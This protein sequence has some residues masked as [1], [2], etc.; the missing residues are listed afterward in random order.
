MGKSYDLA[1]AGAGFAGL[2]LA[3]FLN[4]AEKII[5]EAKSNIGAKQSSTCCTPLK[6]IEKLNCREAK[7]VEFKKFSVHS[8]NK[9]ELIV[10]LPEKFCTIDYARFCRKMLENIKNA[11]TI[12]G[13]RASI[14]D[15][16]RV[17]ISEKNRKKEI[18]ARAIADCSGWHAL[19]FNENIKNKSKKIPF[20]LEIEAEI[21]SYELARFHLFYGKKY[22]KKGYAWVFPV[23]KS[24][25]RVGLGGFDIKAP[26]KE[27]ARFLNFL[28]IENNA[29]EKSE[30]HANFIP[31]IGLRK[32]KP[33]KKVFCIGD[34]MHAVL[35][36]SGE[37]IRKSMEHAEI[38]TR[39]LKSYLEGELSLENAFEGYYR[40]I[41]SELPFYDNLLL[42]QNIAILLPEFLRERVVNKLKD[43]DAE[44]LTHV[45]ELYLKSEIK[46]SKAKIIKAILKAII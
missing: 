10:N 13:A 27:L 12:T 38:C 41:L 31:C 6:T 43:A 14:K 35:P 46:H 1:I 34:S 29:I 15:E 39:F 18:E 9:S 3:Y 21:K 22:V 44:R 25:A 5:I 37:G 19:S 7:L 33:G 36:L 30:I 40:A 32:N 11:E 8:P 45:F 24:R 28:G 23:S 26:K 20:G 4:G 42:T 16:K 17:I 2:S